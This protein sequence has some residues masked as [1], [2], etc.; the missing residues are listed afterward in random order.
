MT[1]LME[2]VDVL[3]C[4]EEDAAMVFSI[5]SKD[6]DVNTGTLNDV[7]ILQL[8]GGTYAALP[9]TASQRVR[10]G[11]TVYYYSNSPRISDRVCQNSGAYEQ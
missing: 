10:L 4:N 1:Q 5:H 6:T 2:F 8:D 3:V 9:V 11:Q 7:A